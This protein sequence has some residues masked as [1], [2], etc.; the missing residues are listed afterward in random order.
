MGPQLGD[1]LTPQIETLGLP[2]SAAAAWRIRTTLP[3]LNVQRRR[4]LPRFERKRG[5]Q[6]VIVAAPGMPCKILQSDSGRQICSLECLLFRFVFPG[7][8]EQQRYFHT[9]ES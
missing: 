9:R 5:T 2:L 7:T 1:Q 8:I 6:R 4:P 3:A